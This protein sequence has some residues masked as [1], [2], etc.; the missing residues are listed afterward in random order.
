M[1]R[2]DAQGDLRVRRTH[3]LLWEALV[4][5]LATRPFEEI[6]VTNICER[7]MVHRTTF[8]KH[9]EDKY[10]LLAKGMRQMYDALVAESQHLPP[11]AFSTDHPP[12]YFIRLFEH[13]AENQTFYRLML[14][15]EGVGRFQRLVKDYIAE[16]AQTRMSASMVADSPHAF[17]LAMR[18]Q[19]LAGG[20]LSLLVWWLEH[21]M[22]LTP[23]QMAQFLLSQHGGVAPQP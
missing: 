16:V 13:V 18:V 14:T 7:A 8:Y 10:A 4:A 20:V 11:S 6:T 19:Y 23:H 17:P 3:K 21:D 5:E 9:Y 22:P 15:G 12:P 1:K 2:P